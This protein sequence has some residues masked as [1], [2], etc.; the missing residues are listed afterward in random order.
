MQKA[1]GPNVIV[2]RVLNEGQWVKKFIKQEIKFSSP[3]FS[4]TQAYMLDKVRVLL[5]N[6]S[7]VPYSAKVGDPF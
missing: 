4:E 1:A 3:N 7:Q 6:E 2:A 5:S